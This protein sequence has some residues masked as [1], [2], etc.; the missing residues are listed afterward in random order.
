[1]RDFRYYGVKREEYDSCKE[2]RDISNSKNVITVAL[3]TGVMELVVSIVSQFVKVVEKYQEVYLIFGCITLIF[4][5]ISRHKKLNPTIMVYMIIALSMIFAM[6]ISVPSETE[7]AILFPVSIILLPVLFVEHAVR[8]GFFLIIVTTM[9]CFTVFH[10]KVPDVAQMDMYNSIMFCVISLI[11]QYF[12]NRKVIVGMVSQAKNERLLIAYEKIQKELELK[13]Q[14]DQ[15]TGLYNRTVFTDMAANFFTECRT[16]GDT[17]YLVM[18]DL[19]KFK[20]INDT[21]GHQAGDDVIIK[22]AEIIKSNLSEHEYG[23]RLGGD[24]YMLALAQRFHAVPVQKVM[25]NVLESINKIR[26]GDGIY[27][28]SSIGIV[29][30]HSDAEF[31]D[32]YRIA[33]EALYKAKALGRNRIHMVSF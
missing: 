10:V 22:V 2:I 8:M 9:F 12:V 3:I 17:G 21:Y 24:E 20:R 7:K 18:M 33:D 25:E 1:M 16:E 19:D 23:A 32:M 26:I 31:D 29:E 4:V 14:T 5:L 11:T 13:A 15:M 27:A 6:T 30:I 28:G